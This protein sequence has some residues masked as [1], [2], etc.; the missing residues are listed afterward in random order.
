MKLFFA[1]ILIAL[2]GMRVA[3]GDPVKVRNGLHKRSLQQA[4]RHNCT[5]VD[6]QDPSGDDERFYNSTRGNMLQQTGRYWKHMMKKRLGYDDEQSNNNNLRR[7]LQDSD[8]SEPDSGDG[9]DSDRDELHCSDDPPSL[10]QG[11]NFSNSVRGNCTKFGDCDDDHDDNDVDCVR[12]GDCDGT[13]S[14]DRGD[15]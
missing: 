15:D 13:G 11:R 9:G 6:S 5:G 8:E 10:D 1:V 12:D 7:V 4:N 2:V 3:N 14:Q